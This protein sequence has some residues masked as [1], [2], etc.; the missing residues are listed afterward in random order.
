MCETMSAQFV[1]QA[2]GLILIVS[3]YY[4]VYLNHIHVYYI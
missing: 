1:Q 2:D 3:L 4:E